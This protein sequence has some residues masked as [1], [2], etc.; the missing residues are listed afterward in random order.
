M[1]R[2]D[3]AVRVRHDLGWAVIEPDEIELLV[4]RAFFHFVE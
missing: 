1:R 2:G 4:A 3:G